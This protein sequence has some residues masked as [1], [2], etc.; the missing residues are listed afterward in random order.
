MKKLI[1]L[2]LFFTNFYLFSLEYADL[3]GTYIFSMPD[4][5]RKVDFEGDKLSYLNKGGN[6]LTTVV[7]SFSSAYHIKNIDGIDFIVIKETGAKWLIIYSKDY[8]LLYD[9]NGYPFFE[10]KKRGST[11]FDTEMLYHSEDMYKCDSY[12]TE[13]LNGKTVKYSSENFTRWAE[14]PYPWVEGEKGDGIGVK[15]YKKY[16]TSVRFDLYIT[17]SNGFVSYSRPDLYKKNNRVK[18]ISVRNIT[19]N[20]VKIFEIDDTPNF[21][22]L[23]IT[24]LLTPGRKDRIEIEILDIYRGTKYQDTA[25][26]IL[27]A[28]CPTKGKDEQ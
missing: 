13:E 10:G 17:I 26:N 25:I 12:L 4:K 19:N 24:D 7:E 8:I 5:Y 9:K 15:I 16:G 23:K 14:I 21:Q 11:F 6:D 1:L 27:G 28:Y 2:I 3:E 20:A 18:K 22:F